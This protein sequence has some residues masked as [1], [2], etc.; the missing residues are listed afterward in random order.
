MPLNLTLHHPAPVEWDDLFVEAIKARL[1]LLDELRL[2]LTGAITRHIN[3]HLTALATHG[4][5]C[6]AIAGVAGVVARGVVLLVAKMV[7]QFS[8]QC[9]LN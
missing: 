5:R 2:E 7:S 3:L 1:V 6:G 4:L 9:A 8:V